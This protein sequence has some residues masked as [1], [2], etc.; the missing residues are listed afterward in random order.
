MGLMSDAAEEAWTRIAQEYVREG[1]PP[2]KA[3]TVNLPID[4]VILRELR[5]HEWIEDPL[6]QDPIQPTLYRLSSAGQSRV[7]HD[8]PMSDE[9]VALV[10]KRSEEYRAAGLPPMLSA[11]WPL[12]P[13]DR[14]ANE[15][16]A[17]GLCKPILDGYCLTVD[18]LRM[19]TVAR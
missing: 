16:I 4:P 14:A 18:G 8:A 1:Y 2:R 7:M 12:V 15:L 9:A 17:R 19:S 13:G 11:K 3:W 6:G 5:E 10:K